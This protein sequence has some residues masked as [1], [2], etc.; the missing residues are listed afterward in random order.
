[1]GTPPEEMCIRDSVY[2]ISYRASENEREFICE[3]AVMYENGEPMPEYIKRLV[4]E[5][6][7][8]EA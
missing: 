6:K 3:A 5:C 7:S 8:H 1:M 2:G 4:K